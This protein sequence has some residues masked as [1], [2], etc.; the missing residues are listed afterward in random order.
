MDLTD[1]QRKPLANGRPASEA[2]IEA[3]LDRL[4]ARGLKEYEASSIAAVLRLMHPYIAKVWGTSK[5][6][7]G[8]GAVGGGSESQIP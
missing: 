2:L 4:A 1:A 8:G 7:A 5:P 3:A 6:A